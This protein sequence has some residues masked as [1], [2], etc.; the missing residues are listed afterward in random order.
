MSAI[1][2]SPE[3][4]SLQAPRDIGVAQGEV[5]DSHAGPGA[6]PQPSASINDDIWLLNDYSSVGGGGQNFFITY[7]SRTN[8]WHRVNVLVRRSRDTDSIRQIIDT[9]IVTATAASPED[10]SQMIYGYVRG[11][12]QD[13][14]LGNIITKL[15]I[16]ND[17]PGKLD[18]RF[19]SDKKELARL[20]RLNNPPITWQVLVVKEVMYI[21]Q[22]GLWTYNVHCELKQYTFQQTPDREM[23]EDFM[24]ELHVLIRLSAVHI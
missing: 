7:I 12:I 22:T 9:K 11:L 8:S 13:A 2:T 20:S 16:S 24:Y 5:D 21:R 10:G 15:V 3:E 18:I 17:G 6:M 4:S 23:L 14:T 19:S 1:N